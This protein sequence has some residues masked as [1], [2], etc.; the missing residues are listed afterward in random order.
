MGCHIFDH[1]E[2]FISSLCTK[3]TIPWPPKLLSLYIKIYDIFRPQGC[4]N[5]VYQKTGEAAY[6]DTLFTILYA[7]GLVNLEN[8]RYINIFKMKK[9]LFD[10]LLMYL[11]KILD[12]YNTP[13][14][15]YLPY[16]RRLK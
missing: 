3:W 15:I 11:F 1:A 6:Q 14:Q 16:C 9:K 2:K 5:E 13:C 10:F 8:T 7:E 12:N 4:I